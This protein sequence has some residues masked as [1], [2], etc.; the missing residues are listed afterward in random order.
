MFQTLLGHLQTLW[1]NR[2][3]SYLYVFQ[4]DMFRPLLSHLL[5]LWEN[6]SKN[7]LYFNAL[8]DP[9]CIWDPMVN[10]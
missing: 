8:W 4:G 3:K 2:P 6:R 9:K 1:E 5:A 7:Y 10:Y